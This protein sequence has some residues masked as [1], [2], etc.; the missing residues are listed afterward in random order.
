[1]TDQSVLA[2]GAILGDRYEVTSLLGSGGF[3]EVVG[4]F[5]RH[6]GGTVAV[7]VLHKSATDV[8]PRAASRMRQEAEILRSIEHPNIVKI[9]EVGT[10]E[11]GQFL[12]M[13]LIEGRGLDQILTEESILSTPRVLSLTSQLLQALDAVHE[14]AILHRDLKPENILLVDH[15]GSELVKLVDFGVAKAEELQSNDPDEAI[16]LVK[17]RVGSFVGTPRYAA[18]EIV[19]GDPAEASAD[20]FCVGLIAYEALAGEPLIK[21]TTHT[22]LMNELVF[23]RPFDL[24]AVPGNWIPWLEKILEKNPEQRLQTAREALALLAT[25]F[26]PDEY[27]ATPL[28]LFLDQSRQE[29]DDLDEDNVATNAWEPLELDYEALEQSRLQRERAEPPLRPLPRQ[30]T[31]GPEPAL[32]ESGGDFLF[33]IVMGGVALLLLVFLLIVFSG[34]L[35]P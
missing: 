29:E 33:Y 2:T 24:S 25:I 18:P 5:D 27:E 12:V 1:M 10:F 14:A 19:V 28:A 3:G 8:D 31:P 17:T 16:T 6:T 34:A 11:G 7:K 32:R 26:P 15:Q 23:P 35:A 30:N 21:G 20:L 4:A 13:E 9:L 22:E